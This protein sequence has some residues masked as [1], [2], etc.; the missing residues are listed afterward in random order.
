MLAM[1][2]MQL[3][4]DNKFIGFFAFHDD[5]FDTLTV[6]AARRSCM[7]INDSMDPFYDT[8][9]SKKSAC[10]I[11]SHHCNDDRKKLLESIDEWAPRSH[12][13]VALLWKIGFIYVEKLSKR[14]CINFRLLYK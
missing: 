11:L 5:A 8:C 7:R 9:E 4:R 13:F 10:I 2:R 3:Q 12:S 6:S 1:N 14:C